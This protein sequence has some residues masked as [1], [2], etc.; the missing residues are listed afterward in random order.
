MKSVF[1]PEF[2]KGNRERLQQAAKADVLVL[3]GHGQLQRNGDGTFPFRQNSN[4]WYLTGIDE[5]DAVLVMTK[6]ESFVMLPGRTDVK[7]LWDGQVDFKELAV[8]SG[9]DKILNIEIGWRRLEKQ[10]KSAK[11]IGRIELPSPYIDRLGF[12]TNPAPHAFA[13][14]LTEAAPNTAKYLN[15]APMLAA[16]RMVKQPL[17]L[18]V[19]QHAVDITVE[20]L[21]EVLARPFNHEYELEAAI[22]EGFR[23]RGASGHAY[24][25][26]VASGPNTCTIH[27]MHNNDPIDKHSLILVDVGA[28]VNNYAADI[29]RT[30]SP[31]IASQRQQAVYDAVFEV[32]EW[33]KQ[34]LKPGVLIKEYEEAVAAYMGKQLKKLK[35]ITTQDKASI[36]KY[37]PHATGHSLGL[38]VHDAADYDRPLEPG[39]VLTVEPGIYIPEE[40]IGVRLEDDVLITKTGIKVLSD[41]LPRTLA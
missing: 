4:F 31:V 41:D 21:R 7:N 12:Y 1:P 22:T 40:K 20:T 5:P 18:M 13:R 29:S 9:V 2:F 24:D 38:D 37:Y 34:Q 14:R 30:V 32:Q 33:A 23:R 3:A 28:E 36:R 6:Q 15:I 11:K 17:E 39:M 10:L 25:P 26:I 27:A 8:R 19:I 35:L 16:Q